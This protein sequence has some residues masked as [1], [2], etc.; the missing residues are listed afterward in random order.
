LSTCCNPKHAEPVGATHVIE[1]RRGKT[2]YICETCSWILDNLGNLD[3][4]IEEIEEWEQA[5]MTL[6]ERIREQAEAYADWLYDQSIG[7]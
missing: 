2:H 6:E 3:T 1:D 7:T 4:F 5:H